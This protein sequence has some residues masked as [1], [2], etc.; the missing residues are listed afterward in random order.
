MSNANDIPLHCPA[1]TK[2][3]KQCGGKPTASG[4]CVAHSPQ[5]SEKRA[6]GGHA[7][8]NASRATKLLPARLAPIVA[9]LEQVFADLGDGKLDERIKV[10]LAMATVATTIGRLIQAGE[11]EERL[12]EVEQLAA[13]AGRF[14]D[15]R[16]HDKGPVRWGMNN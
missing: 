14:R 15:A 12:R 16:G 8:S 6:M 10:A 11:Y 3:G 7:H 9:R 13:D 2:A 5:A 1:L 4:Y